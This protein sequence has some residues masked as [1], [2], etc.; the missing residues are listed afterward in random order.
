MT[1]KPSFMDVELKDQDP[2]LAKLIEVEDMRQDN[3]IIL[4]ASESLTSRPVREALSTSF[5]NMYAEGYP[6][7]RMSVWEKENL[8]DH[9][10]HLSFYRRY[11]DNRYYKGVDIIDI[12][13]S[14]A[15]KRCADLFVNEHAPLE[16]IFVNV[17]PLSGAAANNAVYNAFLEPGDTVMGMDLTSGG[18]LT[19]GSPVNRSG[20]NY[21]IV[22]YSVDATGKIDYIDIE[23][24][25]KLHRP[26]M[27]ISGFSAYPGS[28][29]WERLR[30]IAHSVGALLLADVSHVAGLIVAGEY[31][32]PVG[33][34]DVTTFTTHKTMLGPR[35]AII[36]TTNRDHA[37]KVNMGVFPGEQGGPHENN[38]AAKA[39]AFEIAKSDDFKDVQQRIAKNAL[40]LAEGFRKR[41]IGL[42]YGG[43]DTHYVLVD[44]KS[45]KSSS[46]GMLNGEIVSRILEICGIVCNKNTI[47]GDD[48]AAFPS[49]LRLGTP[50]ITQRGLDEDDMEELADIITEALKGMDGFSY[51]SKSGEPLGRTKI[52]YA[53]LE[54]VKDRVHVLTEKMGRSTGNLWDYPYFY[55][56]SEVCST[57]VFRIRGERASLALAGILGIDV[58][59][60]QAG[61]V[62]PAFISFDGKTISGEI[63]LKRED[64]DN[65]RAAITG[66][67]PGRIITWL[68][69]LSDGYL[70]FD[71]D[72][73]KKI[74]GPFVVEESHH[75]IATGAIE[76]ADFT[77]SIGN[78]N[79]SVIPPASGTINVDSADIV[80]S[81]NDGLMFDG[82]VP[83]AGAYT[84]YPDRF[85]LTKPFFIGQHAI[86]AEFTD[87]ASSL[88][89]QESYAW[90]EPEAEL[91]YSCLYDEHVKLGATMVPF[92]GWKMPVKYGESI[93]DEHDVV[94]K[95]A[96]LFDVS[97]M[98]VFGFRGKEAARFLDTVTSNY[99][100]KLRPGEAQYSY[101]LGENGIPIDDI[102]VYMID[103]EDY[104][105]VVNAANIDKD[106][107]W[108]KGLL[109]Q[110]YSMD[111]NRPH[112][113]AEEIPEFL[114][115]KDP[116]H[117]A[118]TRV[119][120]AFQGPKTREIMS[121]LLPNDVDRRTLMTLK[122]SELFR[123]TLDDLRVIITR[124]GYTG[125]E[126]G[127][128]IFV[129]PDHAPQLWNA[130]LDA[131]KEFGAEPVGLGARDSTRVEAGFPL[132]GHELAGP[133]T[134]TPHGA[135]YGYFVK[136]H[137]PFFA[138]RDPL[139]ENEK[140]RQLGI[141]RIRVEKGAQILNFGDYVVN[142][143]GKC[144]GYVTSSAVVKNQQIALAYVKKANVTAPGTNV[145][146]IPASKMKRA[147]VDDV[148]IGSTLLPAIKGEVIPR[149]FNKK[150][151]WKEL[152]E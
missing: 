41:G 36:I 98:G 139:Q 27:I 58:I 69:A 81:R 117:G 16:D 100:M 105:M 83:M 136:F 39:V 96:G 151:E 138:G 31:P 93:A 71:D 108:I 131:G 86:E 127:F 107:A 32:N 92:A 49:G 114:D 95:R 106:M 133:Y 44:L 23:R 103:I 122:G 118:D 135:G 150:L 67:D 128:E 21:K 45:L 115:L 89:K 18:H 137:K 77:F 34:A 57:G 29:D 147:K 79:Y 146:L 125:E 1:G 30:D 123:T 148:K 63:Q 120:I 72:I 11:A 42:A 76:D 47:V 48:K 52:D 142:K 119:D 62:K 84:T 59:N 66:G 111:E 38:I 82:S 113:K 19:H 55:S 28:V 53:V 2:E 145:G 35:G 80:A 94:R 8:S 78:T 15:Q 104:M 88:G 60:M 4:I 61:D 5:T 75:V 33:I 24:K 3:K 56:E 85:V 68:R 129:H 26:K 87:P 37:D 132:Y 121:K 17:Q 64:D 134:M 141:A 14:L 97:H 102:Y 110:R 90:E 149:F 144:I 124:T 74:D 152:Y 91:Q 43:T 130:L 7:T 22:P 13:E 65:F 70:K 25:A 112:V 46:G 109:E 6:S 143:N 99:V 50:I 140:N 9:A 10:R 54:S 101:L 51:V 116:I 126:F 12:M 40:A 73:M 20:K